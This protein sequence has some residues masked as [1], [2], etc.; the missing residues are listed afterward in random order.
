MTKKKDELEDFKSPPLHLLLKW[1]ILE[2]FKEY[3]QEKNSSSVIKAIQTFS[4]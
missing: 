3:E 1:E 2:N 4:F